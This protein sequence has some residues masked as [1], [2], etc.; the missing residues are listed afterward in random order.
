MKPAI[1][2][3]AFHV[4]T[5]HVSIW[6][7]KCLLGSLVGFAAKE[8]LFLPYKSNIEMFLLTNI[9]TIIASAVIFLST[10]SIAV[11][12]FRV[13]LPVQRLQSDVCFLVNGSLPKHFSPTP[14]RTLLSE[15]GK[16]PPFSPSTF[17]HKKDERRQRSKTPEKRNNSP[18][19]PG[20]G[21][22]SPAKKR[23]RSRTPARVA[24]F[25]NGWDD[26]V[27]LGLDEQKMCDHIV[28]MGNV[29]KQERGSSN[30]TITELVKQLEYG[31]YVAVKRNKKTVVGRIE[32][33]GHG[34]PLRDW[35]SADVNAWLLRRG[36]EKFPGILT[37]LDGRGPHLL[38]DIQ[39]LKSQLSEA[40]FKT[41][42]MELSKCFKHEIDAV[43]S[44]Y[45]S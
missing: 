4:S 2:S 45:F 10:I 15:I 18:G 7:A 13:I 32:S 39:W 12:Y 25:S 33:N 40:D 37:L 1:E 28:W 24:I 17:V 14:R 31:T 16:L 11:Y 26:K 43:P 36:L 29:I 20:S 5:F 34:I 41:L 21:K 8:C 30:W 19:G 22:K 6:L 44:G 3:P 27:G 9:A 42:M 35:S 38:L 23:R